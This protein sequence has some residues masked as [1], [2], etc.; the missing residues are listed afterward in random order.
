[1]DSWC[2]IDMRVEVILVDEGLAGSRYAGRVISMKKG[3]ALI[4]F[5]VRMPRPARNR[6][7][8]Q[9]STCATTLQSFNEE[10]SEALLREWHKGEN[11]QP[12]PPPTPTGFHKLLTHGDEVEVRYDDGW[13]RMTFLGTRQVEGVTEFNVWSELYQ[14]GRWVT[15]VEVRPSWQRWGSKWRKLDQMRKVTQ[16]TKSSAKAPQ[17]TST[18][19]KAAASPKVAPPSIAPIVVRRNTEN[20]TPVLS[21][22]DTLGHA[23]AGNT[24]EKSG[25]SSAPPAHVPRPAIL[26]PPMTSATLERCM[27][28]LK[29]LQG[30]ED[31]VWFS[32]PVSSVG[33]WQETVRVH[34]STRATDHAYASQPSDI[35]NS[36][37][38]TGE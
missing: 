26:Q 31:A 6:S 5:E 29:N 21:V 23:N 34:T 15:A 25:S 28:V 20:P 17:G 1:M 3:Q 37:F 35:L 2:K 30:G 4:Q 32:K 10:D 24:M 22:P 33:G 19:P 12:V 27:S 9:V 7:M 14:V 16:S 13:W 18:S 36:V 38:S 8:P 11:L